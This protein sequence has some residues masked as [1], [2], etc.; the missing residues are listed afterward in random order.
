MLLLYSFTFLG[1]G[2]D[3]LDEV[4]KQSIFCGTEPVQVTPLRRTVASSP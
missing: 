4:K 3:V 1:E 2:K